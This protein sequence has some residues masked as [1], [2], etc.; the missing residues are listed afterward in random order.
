MSRIYFHSEHGTAEVSGVERHNAGRIC[1]HLLILAL[2]ADSEFDDNHSPLRALLPPGH[3]A[4]SSGRF[5]SSFRVACSG[6]DDMVLSAG[7][8]QSTP[9]SASLNTALVMGSDPIRLLARLHGQCEIHA[10]VEG[11]N[12]E[13]LAGIISEGL[14][15]GVMRGRCHWEDAVTLLRSGDDSPVV[16]SYSVCE[17]F[18]NRDVAG[19]VTPADPESGEPDDDC[20][21]YT[22]LVRRLRSAS[23][24]LRAGRTRTW[25]SSTRTRACSVPRW[26]NEI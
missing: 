4:L 26:K 2:G 8:V 13:W 24:G 1:N 16:T 23:R 9:F 20:L 5:L 19:W 3:Y 14:R 11:P 18:P 25:R 6:F 21:L 15:S 10:Y 22:S 7:G 12:R 17:S